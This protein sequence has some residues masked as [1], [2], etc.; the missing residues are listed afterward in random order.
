MSVEPYT[1]PSEPFP[2]IAGYAF[3]SD[4]EHR[5]LVSPRGGVEWLC[6]PNPDSPSVFGSMLDRSAGTFWLAP[7]RLRVPSQRRYLP[8]T[9][10]VETT[11]RAAA[12][13]LVVHDLLVMEEWPGG[14][15]I[16]RY[17]RAPGDFVAA[18]TLLRI[19][20]CVEGEVEVALNCLPVFD[21]GRDARHW[22]YTGDDYSRARVEPPAPDHP[23]LVLG[24][25]TRVE[26]AGGRAYCHT[27]LS[28]GDNLFAA[29]SWGG[30]PPA[31]FED[32]SNQL[33]ETSRYW[34]EWLQAG[35]IPDHPWKTPL[36]R[37]ALTLKG[38]SHAPTGAILA[39]PTTSLPET[40]GGERN[41]DYRYSWIRDSAFMLRGLF[42]LGFDW[43]A[44][45]YFAFLTDTIAQGPLQIMY[46][47]NG[48]RELQESTLDHLSGYGGSRPV[49]IGNGAY[50]QRQHDVWGMILDSIAI[51]SGIGAS[52]MLPPEAWKLIAGLVDQA[53]TEWRDPDRGI[54]EVRGDPKHFTASKV[55]CWV[56]LDRGLALARERG[57]ADRIAE[58]EP[59]AEEI[60]REV[61]E[62]GVG[63]R[64]HFVQHYE[65][66]A[67]DASL[68]LIPLFGF[69]PGSDERVR[70]TVLA[71]ADEL[72]EHGL[73][74]RYR[75]DETDDGLSGKEGTF[76]ICSFWLASALVEIGE[77]GRA[78]ALCEKL[79]SFA[80]PLGLYAEEIDAT[81]GRHLGN[82]PQAFTHLALID[83]V[84]KVIE[85]TEEADE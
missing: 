55:M 49:R 6:L 65:T 1:P 58:W 41:W 70:N 23:D 9:M 8:G 31:T 22:E 50:D 51:H 33:E 57:D 28:E 45:E 40:P 26:L 15:R 54:W 12:G 4:C 42:T 7:E 83:A 3:L 64:G 44:F 59:V 66:D 53:A 63:E 76:A 78:R 75:V 52:Q 73:V 71:I 67:L 13:W 56:A 43:E 16:E 24:T 79:L 61:C 32:A 5:A 20:T 82:F 39:A 85:T 11:W 34:R 10:V 38:L 47:V 35:K 69:L 27:R 29:L 60:K 84:T 48:E 62:H 80:S 2:P 77:H 37:S 74:L 21:Y 18:G 30:E 17:R 68:L 46:G 25:N 14:E 19:A 81:S 36:E 72:T